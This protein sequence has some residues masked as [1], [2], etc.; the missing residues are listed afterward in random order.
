VKPTARTLNTSEAARQLG[1]SAKALRLYEERG[2]ITPARTAAG[3]RAYDAVQLARAANIVALRALGLSLADVARALD[4]DAHVLDR[5]LAAHEMSLAARALEIRT[6]SDRVRSLRTDLARGRGPSLSEIVSSIRPATRID[7]EFDLPWPWGGERFEM[8]DIQRLNFIVGPLG[9]GKTRL[10]MKIAEALPNACFIGVDRLADDR[11][12]ASAR[13]RADPHLA[14]RVDQSVAEIVDAG[15]SPSDALLILITMLEA[16]PSSNLVIDVPELGLDAAT[17]EALMF[18]LRCRATEIGALFLLTRS[19][20]ILDLEMVRKDESIILCPANHSPPFAVM[21]FPGARGRE[22]V[23]TCLASPEVRA[24]TEG[25]IA[26]R[27]ST[28]LVDAVAAV[29]TAAGRD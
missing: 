3:W 27:P 25:V 12:A 11:A 5:I 2:L 10:A 4:R 19:D 24:R 22:A 7:V 8:H 28:S 26:W 1:I 6:A 23:A 20:R 9:S 29:R 17:Q 14:A 15:G 21:P 16:G 18:H 13:R